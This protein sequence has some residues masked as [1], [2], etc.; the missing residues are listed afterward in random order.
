MPSRRAE[1]EERGRCEASG[2]QDGPVQGRLGPETSHQE[3]RLLRRF[4]EL[5][6]EGH[7]DHHGRKQQV[8]GT[9]NEEY[10]GEG[11]LEFSGLHWSF[12]LVALS[13]LA[14]ASLRSV[15]QSGCH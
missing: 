6:L 7:R 14:S 3:T 5:R 12:L 11:G 9:Q 15:L 8:P 13:V 4:G 10:Q 2:Q 1:D